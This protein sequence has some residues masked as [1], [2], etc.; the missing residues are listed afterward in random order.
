MATHVDRRPSWW[1]HGVIYQIYPRS[2]QDSDGDGTGDLPG[3]TSRLD[4]LRW[5]GVDALWLS[6]IYPSPMHD[7]GYDVSDY[8]AVSPEFGTLDDFKVLL[9]EAHAR[10]IR[11]I[12]DLVL[13]HTSHEHPWFVES[14]SS[15]TSEKRSWY[16][17]HDGAPGARPRPPNN[18]MAAFGGSAWEWDPTTRQF[19]LHSFLKEQPDVNWREPGLQEAMWDVIR[20]WL[21]LG[22]DG[23][24]LDVVN[25]FLKDDRLRDNPSRLLGFRAYERQRHLYDRNRPDTID[26]MRRIRATV[27]AYPDRVTVGEVYTPAPGDPALAASYYGDGSGL[28]MAFNFAFLYSPWRAGAFARA[29]DRWEGLLGTDLW[30]NYTLS[31]HDQ[32]RA[33][34]RYGRGGHAEARAR[35]AAAMLLTLR[36]TP[37]LYYGEEIGMT[38]GRIPRRRR[39]DPVGKRYWPFNAGRDPSRT[40][41]QWDASRHAGFSTAEP[42]LPMNRDA[43]VKHVAAQE[44][45]PGSL[46]HWYRELIGVRQAEWALRAG[47]Y[48][49]LSAGHGPI[50]S[51]L[52]QVGEERVVVHLNFAA[53]DR[54][55]VMPDGDR[56]RVLIASAHERGATLPPG[57]VRLRGYGVIVARSDP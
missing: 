18:W 7:F 3:I 12:T 53:S 48:T 46:L 13:N 2:F 57:R 47:S 49:R 51:Y 54:D 44:A 35:V 28:H 31:N 45:D 11:V 9:H 38:N 22:V 52:R 26:L 37:F 42:W 40:P 55:A 27:D 43:A 36:G 1:R 14:A 56:W 25:W 33:F 21:D 41:M 34:G 39:R 19:F 23:F 24:R 30:P 10:G 17:W 16:L 5:L 29:V 15:R 6:P 32:L 20:F 4:Y 8:T 50:L